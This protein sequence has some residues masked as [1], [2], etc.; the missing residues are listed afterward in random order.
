MTFEIILLFVYSPTEQKCIPHLQPQ[1]L[2]TPPPHASPTRI[3]CRTVWIRRFSAKSSPRQATAQVI[4]GHAVATLGY[5]T[6]KHGMVSSEY[7]LFFSP[8][9]YSVSLWRVL[10][11]STGTCTNTLSVRVIP[12]PRFMKLALFLRCLPVHLGKCRSRRLPYRRSRP[13][14]S[15]ERGRISGRIGGRIA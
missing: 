15:P 3:P 9:A 6:K 7:D 4:L 14:E 2:P 10:L 12:S 5:Q 8:L 1:L 13:G 11:F